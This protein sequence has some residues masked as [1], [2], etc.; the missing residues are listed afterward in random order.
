MLQVLHTK[1]ILPLLCLFALLLFAL[2]FNNAKSDTDLP[3]CFWNPSKKQCTAE[4]QLYVQP[5]AELNA[6]QMQRFEEGLKLFKA[7]WT[8]FPLIDGE[9]GLGPTFIASSCTGCH[10]NA[11][12]GA[13]VDASN[14]VIV[15]QLVRISVPSAV[16][17]G[18]PVAH[19]LYGRQLQVFSIFGESLS[20]PATGE[21]EVY[22][23]W[24]EQK[25][26][27]ADGTEIALRRPQ[28]RIANPVFGELGAST[29]MSLR[30]T[31]V[32]LGLGYLDAVPEEAI[33]NLAAQQKA[34]GLNGRPNYVKDDISGKLSL[35][36]FG[37]KAN[38]PTLKQQVAAAHIG[39]MGITSSLYEEQNCPKPQAQC[40]AAH[41]TG[42]H[43]LSD[44]TWDA[45]TL[46]LAYVEAPPQ[47]KTEHTR[48][49]QG[50]KLFQAAGCNGCHVAEL[51]T[52]SF[53]AMPA[54]ENKRFAPYTDLLLHDMGE[55]LADNRPDFLASGRDWRTAPLWG[56][57]LSKRVNGS[58]NFLHDGRARSV[59]EAILWHGGESEKSREKFAH[60]NKAE[61]DLLVDFVNAR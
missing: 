36:R 2:P 50:E 7:P 42:K 14:K 25:K 19:P 20:R 41:Q 40:L 48:F 31:P 54:I 51:K 47:P 52:G 3:E 8:V 60:L 56:I 15:E 61:R 33:L 12:R 16:D 32:L 17:S 46:F 39:D 58:T 11:G 30:N 22:V 27:L 34:Q 59:T 29:M 6:K 18:E 43:E 28:I 21:A 35:G 23:D 24:I 44:A 37:W 38:Q 45:I 53:P 1:S 9:W 55:A 57:G 49:A 26:A 13:T 4:D 5:V 10:V